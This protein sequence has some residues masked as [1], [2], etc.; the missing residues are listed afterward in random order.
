MDDLIGRQIEGPQKTGK[1][2]RALMSKIAAETPFVTQDGYRQSGWAIQR[3]CCAQCSRT[4]K[5]SVMRHLVT[6]GGTRS[7]SEILGVRPGSVYID[8]YSG[9]CNEHAREDILRPYLEAGKTP[10][11]G[12]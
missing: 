2:L 3:I 9:L 8:G 1:Q 10:R 7:A 12:E 11:R 4:I 5:I 6:K